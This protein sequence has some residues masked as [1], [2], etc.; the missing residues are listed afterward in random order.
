MENQWEP[1]IRQFELSDKAAFPPAR[2]VVFTGSSTITMW[3]TLQD[4][5]PFVPAINR[6]FGGSAYS[7]IAHFAG[8]IVRPYKPSLVVAYSGDND[9]ASG[10]SPKQVV[11]QLDRFVVE[12]RRDTCTPM[13]FISVKP[14]PSRAGLMPAIRQTNQLILRYTRENRLMSYVD[15]FEKMLDSQGSPRPELFLE[16]MLHMNATGYAMW[17][18]V[19]TPVLRAQVDSGVCPR[20]I[21]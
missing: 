6:G 10:L 15:V 11:E 9:L 14:S 16:D 1:Q 2:S 18:E 5:F 20:R 3:Q 17:T 8:R 12:V 4:D 7:D 19:L 21:T 13:V